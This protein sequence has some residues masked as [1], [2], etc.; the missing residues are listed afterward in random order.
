MDDWLNVHLY[1]PLAAR[2]ARRLAHTPV[3]PNAVSVFGG[4]LIVAAA[5]LYTRLSPLALAVP[6]GFAAH[7][8]W[9]V[10]DGADGDLARLTGRSSPVG[11]MV[12]GACD[13]LGHVVLYVFLAA[14]L[15]DRLGGWAWLIAS[16]AGASRIVQANHAESRRRTYLWRV[17]DVPWLK[18]NYETDR[19]GAP[20]RRW[21][22]RLID[23]FARLYVAL[24]AAG[25]A[26]AARIEAMLERTRRSGEARERS[27]RVCREES[28]LPLRLQ[29]ALGAN[30]RTLALGASM[31]AGS[32][33]W[34]FLLEAVPMNLLMLAS[35]LAQRRADR[36]IVE[37]LEGNAALLGA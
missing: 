5:I 18:Q 29:T 21:Y 23:P 9:H 11:E 24:A 20:G 37:R 2:L 14:L 3:T 36:R 13:Y 22:V 31:A 32:P 1:H 19:K 4:L 7:A 34:F 25:D 12:D 6:L 17:Y 30:L 35:I 15:D 27:R 28:R 16:L 26:R 33:L 10:V 8:L